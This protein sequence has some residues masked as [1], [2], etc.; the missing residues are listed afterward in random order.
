MKI[1]ISGGHLTPALALM[2]YA[3]T[4]KDVECIFI[5]R[6]HSTAD[7][8]KPAREKTEVSQLNI[9]FVAFSVPKFTSRNP[10]S[11]IADVLLYPVSLIKAVGILMMHRPTV[12]VSFGG[13]LAVP[14]SIA[15]WLLG[16]PIITH[17]Q[18]TVAG[19]ANLFITKLAKK[20]AISFDS[21]AKLFPKDKVVKTGNPLRSALLSK[22]ASRPSWLMTTSTK[23]LLFIA[24]GNQGSYFINST[25][26]QI[27][28]Q[29]T[30][31][32]ILVHSCG[33][34]TKQMNYKKE[35]Q[36]KKSQLSANQ[37]KQ[38]YV[39]NWISENDL[40]WI[41]QHAS[42]AITRAGANTVQE[43]IL[44]QVPSIF[45]PLPFA[46]NDEQTKN[47][48][49]AT[50]T[51]GS[52]IISQNNVSPEK[53]LQTV[54]EQMKIRKSLKKKMAQLEMPKDGAKNLF[55]VISNVSN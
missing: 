19:S 40:S 21:S 25:I 46:K 22:K 37:K 18:T 38:Y 32:Y 55:D 3:A 33:T 36:R 45:I 42:L 31:K 12:F 53:L 16:I 24:G 51:G 14:L 35:L 39:K 44:H 49:L 27:L 43:L 8:S 15:A 52:L 13:Y 47:A 4:Q 11:L 10:V 23:P 48:Q 30:R 7:K 17:E 41:L 29:L 20:V 34:A 1:A 9:P 6:E 5:G 54:N 50:K 26:R 28:P 2:E